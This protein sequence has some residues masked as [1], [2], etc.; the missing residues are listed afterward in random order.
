[1]THLPGGLLVS[2]RSVDEAV[3]A[4]AGGAAIIDVKEPSRGPLGCADADVAAAIVAAVGPAGHCTLACGELASGV[5]M[6]AAHVDRVVRLAAVTGAAPR[7]MKAGPAGLTIDE[8]RAAFAALKSG[9]PAGV[10]PVAVAY[11]DWDRA[12]APEPE[13]LIAAA[14]AVGGL[15]LLIDTSDKAGPGLVKTCGLARLA[16]WVALAGS[17]GIRVALAGRLE[18]A[19]LRLV[20]ATGAA[21]VGVRSAACRGGRMGRVDRGK[22]AALVGTLL[23]SGEQL[24]DAILGEK[25]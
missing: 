22:V 15:T 11:A 25:P 2:V 24:A 14:A 23:E 20:A 7:G 5:P 21:I 6:L 3:E 12:A 1:M 9:L 16:E 17:V 19:E 13:A 8:W 4:V 18:P 10:E